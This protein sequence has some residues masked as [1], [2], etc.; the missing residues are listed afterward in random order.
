M[1][2]DLFLIRRIQQLDQ[3]IQALTREI[4]GL[5][6]HVAAIEARLASHRQD[7][8]DTQALLKAN[9]KEHRH[10]DGQI[11]DFKEKISKLQDQ[12]NSAK[13][14]EQFRAF[15]HEIQFC[16]DHIYQLEERILDK[17]EQAEA[18]QENVVKAQADLKIENAKVARDVEAAG[19]RIDADK[20]DRA[21][22]QTMR[23]ESSA[24]VVPH[25][26]RTYE[27]I[28]T[29]KG[30]A[31]AAVVD[32]KCGACH[33]RLRPQFLQNL[34]H[35]SDG[36]LTCE[37]CGLILHLPDSNDDAVVVEDPAADLALSPPA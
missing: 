17:M 26:M 28:R 18:L 29:A 23:N 37:R 24:Q 31:V 5:P 30:T 9:G 7:L 36:I 2:S 14:N 15:Q 13:T 33:V 10:L 22:Q 19:T 25:T 16:K 21:E 4:D 11:G 1:P 3:R 6:K 12:M 34:R 35:L 8:A 27:R 32:E 20:K